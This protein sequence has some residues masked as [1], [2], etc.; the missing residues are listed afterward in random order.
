M[1]FRRWGFCASLTLALLFACSGPEKVEGEEADVFGEGLTSRELGERLFLSHGCSTCHSVTGAESI[2]P[3]LGEVAGTE[4]RLVDGE[5]FADVSYL[6]TAIQ[7]P[8][9]HIV[10]GYEPLMPENDLSYPEVDAV[11]VFLQYLAGIEPERP[12]LETP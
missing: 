1:P 9:E 10:F 3:S 2:G 12:D 11:V 5:T 4:R 8:Q 7:K 6:Q